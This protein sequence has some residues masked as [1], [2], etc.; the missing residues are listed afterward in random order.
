MRSLLIAHSGAVPETARGTKRW[1]FLDQRYLQLLRWKRVTGTD[2]IAFGPRLNAIAHRLRIP[3]LDAI[4]TLGLK[5]QSLGWWVSRLSERNPMTSPLF[6]RCCYLAVAL[7]I[8]RET[9]GDLLIVCESEAVLATIERHA[10]AEGIVVRRL[11]RPRRGHLVVRSLARIAFFVWRWIRSRGGKAPRV[12]GVLMRTWID[13]ASFGDDDT[14]HDRYFSGLARWL[15]TR[16]TAVTLLPIFVNLTRSEESAWRALA[17][18]GRAALNPNL[19]YSF[20]DVLAAIRVA[21]SQMRFRFAGTEAA[22]LDISL[23]LEEERVDSLFDVGS[24]EAA[25][26]YVLPRHLARRGDRVTAVV[27]AFENMIPE[28]ALI[29]GIRAFLPATKIVSFQ[30]GIPTPLLM[31]IFLTSREAEFAPLPDRIVTNGEFFSR[32]LSEAGL[33]RDLIVDGPALR[34]EYLTKGSRVVG[35]GPAVLVA[36][37]L[38]MDDASELLVKVLAAL[39]DLSVPVLLKPHPMSDVESLLSSADIVALPSNWSI[40]RASMADVLRQA[41]AVVTLSSSTAFEAAAAGARVIVVGRDT[42]LDQNPLQWFPSL[43]HIVYRTDELR[44]EIVR[45]MSSHDA[46]DDA[47]CA[48]LVG[49]LNAVTDETLAAFVIES[50]T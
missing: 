10:G 27:D 24:L 47:A 33:P 12:D 7:E 18:A 26:S 46:V 30:H 11:N 44:A 32:V 49:T 13:E 25:L 5:Y 40:T 39:H 20:R 31:S 1:L 45:A 17:K 35:M 38:P 21:A 6:L 19:L 8:L 34:Y 4:A 3:F 29:M 23:L 15:A 22:G 42:A 36:L 28:K 9:E 50:Q 41:A 43:D 48:M 16:G 2:P 14:F 37:P